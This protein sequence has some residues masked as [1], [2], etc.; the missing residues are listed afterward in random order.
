MK[1]TTLNGLL[2]K[3]DLIAVSNITGREARNVSIISQN[4]CG[5]VVAGWALGKTG[6]EIPVAGDRTIPV[7]GHFEELMNNL[8]SD[9]KPNKV[10][11]YSP[12]D[13][14]Y[15]DVKEVVKHGEGIVDTIFVI[16]EHVSIEVTA[17]LKHLCTKSD[18]TIVG[19]NTL[20]V[21]NVH[22]GV[23]VGAVG[24]NTPLE[25]FIPGSATIIS[26]SGNM[27]NT[28]SSYLQSAGLGVSFGVSTGKDALI[29][30]TLKD[31]LPL[32]EKD[33]N[34]KL[35]ILYIEPGGLYESEAIEYMKKCNFSKPIVVYVAGAI[36]EGKDISLGHAGAVVE[37]TN[38]SAT[39]KMKMFDKYFGMDVFEPQNRKQI[40][41]M[42]KQGRG[43]RVKTLHALVPAAAAVMRALNITRDFKPKRPLT[44]NPWIVELG[45]LGKKLP[46]ILILHAGFIPP[47][48]DGLIQKHIKSGLGRSVSHQSMRNVSH[49]SSNDGEVPRIYGYSLLNIMEE[50]SFAKA[51]ML[52]WLSE[53]PVHEFE[54]D[55]FEMCLIASLTNG[56]GTISAIGAKASASAGNEPNTAMMTT[57]GTMGLTHG[58]NGKK[59]TKML[60]ELFS[61]TGMKDPYSKEN[62][63][64]LGKM[65]LEQVARFKKMKSSSKEEGIEYKKIPCLGHP[66][67]NNKLINFD[68]REQVISKYLEKNNIYNVFLDYYHRLSKEMMRQGATS[69]AHA[70]NVDAAISCVCMGIAWPF[71]VDKKITIERAVDLPFLSFALGR[72]A[73]GA[74]EYLDHRESGTGMDMRVPVAEC[75]YLGRP[76]D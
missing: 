9:K 22:Q 24:G 5:N 1:I 41:E 2:K 13:A 71:L 32:A 46:R 36:A 31:I 37:G 14:V 33:K 62:A 59:A 61:N 18:I 72:V 28:I 25:S 74:G 40:K 54:V 63:P 29:L 45:A 23:R 66:V 7:F 65:V 76:K 39:A 30:T 60:I 67:F 73:G 4:Y 8:P 20:G 11:V 35:I 53:K 21:I 3:G 17:K 6:Q 10:I 64:D 50:T 49:A 26:N 56:P 48:Y 58:G 12:P 44:L 19:C 15:G 68:P 57:L 42:S 52:Y 75:K 27:V 47:P 43:I 55:L 34:T 51:T 16:T 38:T 69:K 70:V